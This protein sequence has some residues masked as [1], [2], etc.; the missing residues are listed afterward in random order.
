MSVQ[1]RV[2]PR[3][4][5]SQRADTLTVLVAGPLISLALFVAIVHGPAFIIVAALFALVLDVPH[6]LH[7]HIRL[8]SEPQLFRR[9][10]LRFFVSLAFISLLCGGLYWAGAYAWLVAI[11][12]YWQPYHVCKQHFGVASLYA[13]KSGFRGDVRP[14][15]DLV[16]CGFLAPLVYRVSHGGFHF[17]DYQFFGQP[18]PFANIVVPTPALGP[19]WAWAAYALFAVALLR[20]IVQQVAQR[21]AGHGLPGFVLVMLGGALGLYNIAYL[22]V[23]DLYAL[24]LIGTSIH[25]LQ[26]HLVCASTVLQ[27]LER[28]AQQPP[29]GGVLGRGHRLVRHMREQRWLWVASLGLTSLLVLSLELPSAGLVPLIVVLHH[30]YLDGVIWKRQ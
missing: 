24:I 13:R 18:L 11:W 8:L 1:T 25:A 30:F 28:S 4:F 26:Y 29:V 15:R 12:V 5:I 21:R 14:I 27:G 9:H 23:G 22:L 3:W 7:T 10:Q 16:L 2:S 17:G 6:V 19:A 20:L